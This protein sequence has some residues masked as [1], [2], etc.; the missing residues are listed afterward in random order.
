MTKDTSSRR[1]SYGGVA[2][3]VCALSSSE[4]VV[5]CLVSATA[6]RDLTSR[7]CASPLFTSTY[8]TGIGRFPV[9]FRQLSTESYFI[10]DQLVDQEP[11]LSVPR[12]RDQSRVK[13]LASNGVIDLFVVFRTLQ[14]LSILPT[15]PTG[16]AFSPLVV[17]LSTPRSRAEQGNAQ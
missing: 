5:L 14:P 9:V 4:S 16:T 11:H 15:R 8:L 10:S 17:A 1:A 3:N 12:P 6:K 7:R 13:S 2:K